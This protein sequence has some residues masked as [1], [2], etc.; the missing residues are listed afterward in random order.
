MKI[1]WSFYISFFAVN[2]RC[3]N[4]LE[5]P[6]QVLNRAD[7]VA[8]INNTNQNRVVVQLFTEVFDV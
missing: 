8:G 2:S 7:F 6:F 4:N 3:V 1:E 5:N